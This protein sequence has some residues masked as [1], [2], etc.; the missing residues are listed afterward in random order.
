MGQNDTEG[1]KALVQTKEQANATRS[2]NN[3]TILMYAV[4]V[5]NQEA[6]AH[7]LSRGADVNATDDSGATP[8][9]LAVWRQEPDIALMLLRH[10]ADPE[11]EA[12]DSMTPLEMA[13]VKGDKLMEGALQEYINSA[14]SKK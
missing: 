6:V 8:L 5:G 13:R 1:F 14:S 3:K 9:H 11:A 2:D 7:L 4:W 12:G 10:G